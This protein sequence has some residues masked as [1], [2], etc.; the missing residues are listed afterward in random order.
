VPANRSR[1]GRWRDC[2]WQ[3]YERAGALEISVDGGR[4]NFPD[5]GPDL[6]WRV[7]ISSITDDAIFVEQPSAA[8]HTIPIKPGVRLIGS[9]S[10]GQN[11]WMFQTRALPTPASGRT[12]G[13]ALE[14]PT[15]VERCQRRNFYRTST[16]ELFL[17]RVEC[18]PL[19]DPASA[20]AAEVANRAQIMDWMRSRAASG[21][22]APH[23]PHAHVPQSE[24][25]VLPDVGPKFHGHLINLGGGGAGLL[26]NQVDAAALDHSRYFWLRIDLTPQ[27]P[28]PLGVTG[29]MVHT[30]IDSS[31]NFYVGIAFEWSF[32]AGH[33]EFIVEQISEYLAAIQSQQNAAA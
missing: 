28:L 7:R 16:V 31:H 24:P 13:L 26:I 33:R 9:M 11:R 23:L 17:P 2:L 29:R 30:H 12:A 15:N 21:P 19:L 5:A 25:I 3:V 18:W 22:H 8:G 27:I 32:N 4:G 20:L 10:I 6:V 14:M 1:T